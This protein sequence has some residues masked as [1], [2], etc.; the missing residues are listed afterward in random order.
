MQ[1]KKVHSRPLSAWSSMKNSSNIKCTEESVCLDL[2]KKSV[3]CSKV[4]LYTHYS[5]SSFTVVKGKKSKK[6]TIFFIFD[7]R[8]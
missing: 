6:L 7:E 4:E 2:N 5:I 8:V 1:G 3:S